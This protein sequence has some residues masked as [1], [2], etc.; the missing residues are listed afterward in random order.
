[1]TMFCLVQ[2]VLLVL[3]GLGLARF[4]EAP[5]DR[6]ALQVAGGVAFAA[7]VALWAFVLVPAL[8]LAPTAALIGLVTFF[9]V[10]TVVEPLFLNI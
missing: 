6:A 1:M 7:V 5:A 10:S 9:F 3:V 4:F 2:G 8:G